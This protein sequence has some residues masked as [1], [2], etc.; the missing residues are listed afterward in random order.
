M[1]RVRNTAD[2]VAVAKTMRAELQGLDSSK[3]MA[4][5]FEDVVKH[6]EEFL[7]A[8]LRQTL[9]PNASLLKEAAL[10]AFK[11][12]EVS[13]ATAFG[14]RLSRAAQYCRL[15]KKQMTSGMKLSDPVKRIASMLGPM[16]LTTSLKKR[17]LQRHISLESEA[18]QP[19]AASSSKSQPQSMSCTP[20]VGSRKVAWLKASEDDILRHYGCK[21]SS[22]SKSRSSPAPVL[23]VV[24]GEL[25][26]IASSQEVEQPPC[27]LWLDSAAG[28]MKRSINGCIESSS[29]APGPDGFALAIFPGSKEIVTEM[30]NLMLAVMKR[31]ACASLKRP[32]AAVEAAG[33]SSDEE[34]AGEQPEAVGGGSPL[35]GDPTPVVASPSTLPPRNFKFSSSV[36]GECKAEFYTSKSYI[37]YL[38]PA[39]GWKLLI[40]ASKGD[41]HANL[42]SL[43]AE[44][45]KGLAKEDLTVIRDSLEA[46]DVN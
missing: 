7:C 17:S 21:P 10:A 26:D 37:R 23:P 15:K 39:G 28:C 29:M 22:M 20:V 3:Y 27:K 5:S 9:R 33:Q 36:W 12:V 30:P 25:I 14:D 35:P 6:Y 43:V 42:Q 34:S 19:T 41:H 46:P 4:E 11:G 13:A 38:L 44:V 31:P 16:K 40:G 45:K 2:A 32:A 18:S 8:L 24:D 1:S